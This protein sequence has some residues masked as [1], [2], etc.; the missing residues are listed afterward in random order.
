MSGK[1]STEEKLLE[2]AK[3]WIKKNPLLATGLAIG[4][5]A[6]LVALLRRN[7]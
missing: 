1:K 2:D 7:K 3:K 4:A 6:M 5:G